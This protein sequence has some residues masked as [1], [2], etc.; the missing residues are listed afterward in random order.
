[1]NQII[2]TNMFYVLAYK[3]L[4][5]VRR[6]QVK[7]F[8]IPTPVVNKVF[9]IHGRYVIQRHRNNKNIVITYELWMK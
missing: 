1:M 6:E 2:G 4:Q 7:E 9:W 3:M 5:E 8:N